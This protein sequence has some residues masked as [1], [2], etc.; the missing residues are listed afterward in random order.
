MR[1]IALVL[2][3]LLIGGCVAASVPRECDRVCA[4]ALPMP[5][6]AEY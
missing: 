5:H 6:V 1:I 4:M 2:S 3:T